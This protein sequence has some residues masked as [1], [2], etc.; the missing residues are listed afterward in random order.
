MKRDAN[1]N[2]EGQALILLAAI[3]FCVVLVSL[4]VIQVRRAY[5]AANYVEETVNSAVEVAIRP[6][7][8]SVVSGDVVID[9]ATAREQIVAE[10]THGAQFAA[11][12]YGLTVA[13]VVDDLVIEVINPSGDGCRFVG[14]TV[15]YESPAVKVTVDV[16]VRIWGFDVALQRTARGSLGAVA[17][18]GEG[19]PTIAVPTPLALPTSV[20]VVTRESGE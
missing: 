9:G 3:L 2:D 17:G 7:A 4:V 8:S 20:V 6:L 14:E 5:Q 1:N 19:R 16:V 11:R 12:D 13:D 18:S 15:C 10:V